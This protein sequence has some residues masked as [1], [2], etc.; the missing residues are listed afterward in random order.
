VVVSTGR[1]VFLRGAS[2]LLGEP[3]LFLALKDKLVIAD[4]LANSLLGSPLSLFPQ[5]V[6]GALHPEWTPT[7]E[8]QGCF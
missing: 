8:Y 5:P 4:D 2:L 6:H 3:L 1:R 7:R